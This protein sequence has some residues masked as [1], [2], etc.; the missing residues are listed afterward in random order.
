MRYGK[1]LGIVLTVSLLRPTSVGKSTDKTDDLQMPLSYHLIVPKKV[2]S[3]TREVVC[4]LR[5]ENKTDKLQFVSRPVEKDI[6]LSVEGF[7]KGL[8]SVVFEEK[9]FES[10]ST[11]QIPL[12]PTCAIEMKLGKIVFGSS[13]E[14]KSALLPRGDYSIT[15]AWR[16]PGF[17][18]VKPGTFEIVQEYPPGAGVEP[19]RDEYPLGIVLEPR[20]KTYYR[21]EPIML[22][23]RIQNNGALPVT[24]MNY[25]DRYKDFFRFEK[26]DTVSGKKIQ[27]TMHIASAITPHTIDG[28]ITLLPG[29]CLSVAIDASDEF[30]TPGK[31]Y[32]AV[33]YYRS[34]ILLHPPESEPYY[35]K[36]YTWTS[37]EVDIVISNTPKPEI[38]KKDQAKDQ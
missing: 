25:F 14:G 36:Q 4:R 20:A 22:S 21:D 1:L 33:A 35:T 5:V 13:E 12:R 16:Q 30:K 11:R 17:A 6:S 29:E 23:V 18:E 34:R 32:V 31:Y 15:A 37:K 27:E 38:P 3:Q 10:L 8:Y 19:S 9:E 24:L 2:G 7:D 26:K 28:W